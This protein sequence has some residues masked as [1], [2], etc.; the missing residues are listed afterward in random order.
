MKTTTGIDDRGIVH[1]AVDLGYAFH[2][3]CRNW[4]LNLNHTI[5]EVTCMACLAVGPEDEDAR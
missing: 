4:K 5:E 3:R 1:W 2:I